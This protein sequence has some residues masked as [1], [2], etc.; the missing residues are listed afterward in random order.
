MLK[1]D[2][3]ERQFLDYVGRGAPYG[4]DDGTIAPWVV[5]A[6]LPFAPEIVLP[7]VHHFIHTLQLHDQHPYGFK[8]SFNQTWPDEHGQSHDGWISPYFFGLNLGPIL[9]M[10]ENHRSGMLWELMR[11]CRWIV[12]GL[13]RA[14][15]AGGWLEEKHRHCA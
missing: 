14:G 12:D 5:V 1:I 6:S 2:G 8:A 7:T 10:V 3:I 4:T 15:F 13:H 9:L 11:G